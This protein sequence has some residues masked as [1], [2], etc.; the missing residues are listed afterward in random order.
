M[1]GLEVFKENFVTHCC[2]ELPCQAEKRIWRRRKQR[3]GPT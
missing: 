1:S 2:D 3:L